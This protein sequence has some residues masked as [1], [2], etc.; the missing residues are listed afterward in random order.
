[1]SQKITNEAGEEIEV[2]TAD[3]VKTQTAAA[4]A[5]KETEF[6]TVKTGL[7]TELAGTKK[8]L[9]ERNTEFKNFREISKETFEKLSVAEQTIYTNTKIIHDMQVKAVE[10]AK[11]TTDAAIDTAIRAKAGKDD[12]LFAKMKEVWGVIAI[13]ATT[14]ELI[15][16]KTMM[17][18]GAIQTTQ[19]D[20]LA[21]VIGFSGG[22]KPPEAAGGDG[23]NFADTDKGKRGAAEL[24]LDLEP[25]KK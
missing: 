16:Q 14:P 6:G 13:D 11:K 5:A 20:L 21:G 2:F 1:M 17:V 12:K 10:D 18:L 15:E 3:E 24:G 8:A 4:V 9:A 22:Y 25:K 23:K 7:E 19:P